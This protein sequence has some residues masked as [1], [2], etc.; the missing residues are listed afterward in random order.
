M[1][2]IDIPKMDLSY[3]VLFDVKGR[4]IFTKITKQESQ[5]KLCRV[6]KKQIGSNGITYLVTHDGRTIRFFD[7][8]I[9]LGDTIKFDLVKNEIVEYYPL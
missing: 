2:V 1:D 9:K 5:Y 4:F 6:E 8:N 7:S 3:R